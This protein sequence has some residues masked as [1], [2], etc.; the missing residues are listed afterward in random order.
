[1]KTLGPNFNERQ[2]QTQR[3]G[4]ERDNNLVDIKDDP[5]AEGSPI[6]PLNMKSFSAD[7]LAPREMKLNK[8]QSDTFE[9]SATLDNGLLIRID[10]TRDAGADRRRIHHLFEILDES[11]GSYSV[12][13][14]IEDRNHLRSQVSRQGIDERMIS[15]IATRLR[16]TLGVLGSVQYDEPFSSSID[17]A[18]IDTKPL[19]AVGGN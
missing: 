2:F 16:K 5:R 4:G 9:T 7:S 1:L 13:L 3:R 17:S 11:P 18:V 14:E 10:E 19:K 12:T 6:K 8:L 15:D